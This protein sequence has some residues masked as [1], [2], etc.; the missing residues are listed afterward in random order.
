MDFAGRIDQVQ[1][2][3]ADREKDAAVVA[4]AAASQYLSGFEAYSD[5]GT[6]TWYPL[7]VVR[8]DADP[9]LFVSGLDAT[10]AEETADIPFQV[11]DGSFSD[12]VTAFLD[13][14]T[15]V[16]LSEHTRAGLYSRLAESF[17]VTFDEFLADLR[18]VKEEPEIAAIG[19]AIQITEGVLSEALQRIDQNTTEAALAG[20]L[21]HGMRDRGGMPGFPSIVASGSRAAHPH[22]APRDVPV[23]EDVVLFDIGARV[24]GYV[25]DIARTV[26]VGE[27]PDRF[28]EAYT[29][30]AEAQ[31]AAEQ[32]LEAGVDAAAVDE[33]ARDA[34][35]AAGYE[36]GYP[37]AGG[38]GVG[39][40]VHESPKISTSSEDTLE[41]GNVV[42]LEPGVY[43][44]GEFG[45][46]IEDIY[47]IEE[48]GAD[49]LSQ[50][51]RVLDD[52]IIS[53]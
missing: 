14:E 4:G 8:R 23:G 29:A 41:A 3:L 43:F 36:E 49:R 44:D 17:T 31:E 30:V 32:Q 18:A 48:D 15:T 16:I 53:V 33:A 52:H 27:P 13:E 20:I 45:V 28:R 21:G 39:L 47:V 10:A 7:V 19:S 40:S 9:C 37:H 5:G 51:S 35:A 2:A 25:A 46:R 34:L 26:Y 22:H 12:A 38:H 1:T 6:R 42:T 50:R 24:D 11:P